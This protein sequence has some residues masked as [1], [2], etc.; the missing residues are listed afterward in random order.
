MPAP[1][2][3]GTPAEVTETSA[4]TI[5]L[6]VTVPAD[7]NVI[8]VGFGGYAGSSL[9]VSSVQGDPA[10]TPFDIDDLEVYYQRAVDQ[11]V[12]QYAIFDTNPNW[13]GPGPFTVRVTIAATNRQ[14][15]GAI[16]C[17]KDV[18]TEG[19]PVN[20]TQ[21]GGNAGSVPSLTVVSSDN[22]LNLATVA[23][24]SADT[25]GDADDTAIT[26]GALQNGS[27]SSSLYMWAEDGTG[28]SDTV[29][30]NASAAWAGVVVSYQ[31]TSESGGEESGFNAGMLSNSNQVV[32]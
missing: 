8:H 26:T 9:V 30:A 10:G 19:T 27:S 28:A 1:S 13:P 20:G 31:G 21:T 11:Y 14:L 7:A 17:L 18:D 12:G 16:C 3:T 5:D 22:A 2:L 25:T 32:Q 4:A 23:S 24:Y 15:K 29:E 6:T